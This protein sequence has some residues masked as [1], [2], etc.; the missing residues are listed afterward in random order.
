MSESEIP[1]MPPATTNPVTMSAICDL[2]LCQA[3]TWR[4]SGLVLTLTQDGEPGRC[5][6]VCHDKED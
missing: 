1:T 3:G 4:C 5:Q 2:E 6:H